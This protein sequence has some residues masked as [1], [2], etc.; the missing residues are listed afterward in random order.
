MN[1]E[2]ENIFNGQKNFCKGQMSHKIYLNAKINGTNLVI[3]RNILAGFKY[4]A[5]YY[6]DAIQKGI[7]LGFRTKRFPH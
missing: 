2:F 6:N 3:R 1:R 7:F 4:I 5:L